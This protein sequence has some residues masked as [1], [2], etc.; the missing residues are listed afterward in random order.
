MSKPAVKRALSSFFAP[1]L[2][3]ARVIA[4]ATTENFKIFFYNIIIFEC[5]FTLNQE[6][7]KRKIVV[8]QFLVLIF[9]ALELES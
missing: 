3:D 8:W 7:N 4:E 1:P 6:Y 9:Y 2:H 5:E